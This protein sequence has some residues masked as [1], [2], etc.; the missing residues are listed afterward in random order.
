MRGLGVEGLGGRVLGLGVQGFGF[1]GLGV[2]GWDLRILQRATIRVT[3]R[4]LRGV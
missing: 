4:V 2:Q 1:R 3:I